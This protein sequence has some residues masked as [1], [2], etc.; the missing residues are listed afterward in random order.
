MSEYTAGAF[1]TDFDIELDRLKELAQNSVNRMYELEEERGSLGKQVD[2]LSKQ[3]QEAQEALARITELEAFKDLLYAVQH[4]LDVVKAHD[5]D[6]LYL[7]T[8]RTSSG[9]A[10]IISNK[11]GV[12]LTVG[13]MRRIFKATTGKEARTVWIE[14]DESEESNE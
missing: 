2:D 10:E 11:Y 9:M 4:D 6:A 1:D 14:D 5:S 8:P 3:L 13:D 12:P 7:L